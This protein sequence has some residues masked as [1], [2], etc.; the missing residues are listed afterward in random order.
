MGCNTAEKGLI[1]NNR[2][3]FVDDEENVTSIMNMMLEGLGYEVTSH[4]DGA[5]AYEDFT[6]RPDGYGLVICDQVMPGMSG[7]DL[8]EKVRGVSPETPV[9]LC[10]GYANDELQEQV[11]KRSVSAVLT[12]PFAMQKL[13]RVIS[14]VLDN[15]YEKQEYDCAS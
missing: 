2:I 15:A 14:A 4:A 8:L 11:E 1:R 3:L 6:Q 10:T 9:I 12:K 13:A 5:K 7:M